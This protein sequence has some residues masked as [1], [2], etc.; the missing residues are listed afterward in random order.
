VDRGREREVGPAVIDRWDGELQPRARNN[1]L[2]DGTR[3]Q[4]VLRVE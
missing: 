1:G 3:G 4:L 2:W